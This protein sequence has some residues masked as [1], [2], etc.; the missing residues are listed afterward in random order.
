MATKDWKVEYDKQA[1]VIKELRKQV[2][3]YQRQEDERYWRVKDTQDK[4][5]EL[6]IE[7]LGK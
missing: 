1:E 4:F 6:L 7:V 3:Y 2:S 5:K